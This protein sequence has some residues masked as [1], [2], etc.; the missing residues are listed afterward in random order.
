[1]SSCEYH[2]L[3]E[4]KALSPIKRIPGPRS[5]G[6]GGGEGAPRPLKPFFPLCWPET[7]PPALA[8]WEQARARKAW[9]GAQKKVKAPQGPCSLL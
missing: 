4:L 7:T 1:M 6:V 8:E 2:S 9:V 5:P 3:L